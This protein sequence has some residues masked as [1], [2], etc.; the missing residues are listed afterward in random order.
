M[1]LVPRPT[2]GNQYLWRLDHS[3]TASDN[4]NLR[5]FRDVTEL[6]FQT[7]DVDGYV[8]SLQRFAVTNWAMQD[9]LTLSPTL[10]NELRI[11][12]QRYDSPTTALGRTQLSD[13]GANYP[14]VMIPQ[15][16]NITVTGYFSLGSNEIFRDTGNIYQIGDTIR[17]IRGRHSI[18][19]GGEFAR[20]EYLGRGSSAN[21]GTFSFDGSISRVA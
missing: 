4:I 11:G 2:D 18:S 21:Q 7:G 5:Y 16:P 15:L 13:F 10:L 12:L 1:S 6:Q 17:R 9:T 14:G 19:L 3:F 8:T 20:N